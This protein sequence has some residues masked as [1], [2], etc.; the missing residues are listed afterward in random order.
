MDAD[1]VTVN[2]GI[3]GSSQ[4]SV[5]TGNDLSS[6]LSNSVESFLEDSFIR[7]SR[8]IPCS[9]LAFVLDVE[10]G[11]SGLRT[12]KLRSNT[13]LYLLLPPR[14]SACFS[15]RPFSSFLGGTTGTNL[16][17]YYLY[18]IYHLRLRVRCWSCC[19]GRVDGFGIIFKHGF[20]MAIRTD[21]FVLVVTAPICLG[22]TARVCVP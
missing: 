22:W 19:V 12:V 5:N 11:E 6:M 1:G 14:P 18:L 20:I 3:E 10:L 4:L 15:V 2:W 13:L 17:G 16:K 7:R 21:G 8:W 9:R